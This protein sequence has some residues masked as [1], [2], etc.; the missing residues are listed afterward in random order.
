MTACRTTTRRA[1]RDRRA[2]SLV[3]AALSTLLVG[4]LLV[5]SLRAAAEVTR[6]RTVL[7]QAALAP[8]LA[9]QLLSEIL[10]AYYADSG[11]NPGFG[12]ESGES[13]GTRSAFN[14]I[15]DYSGWSESPPRSKDGT[16][17]SDYTGWTRSVQVARVSP[18]N[19][20]TVLSTDQGLKRITVTVTDP[21]GRQTTL[22]GLRASTGN[23]ERAPAAQTTYVNWM[24]VSLVSGTGTSTVSTGATLSNQP[25]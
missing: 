18:S 4:I 24:G 19:P 11:S 20:A 8:A 23:Q 5:A 15:D 22:V 2:F 9:Q 3:E 14:D 12:P 1:K 10:A 6:N 16:T 7:A 17:M 25:Q 21:Q 13:T